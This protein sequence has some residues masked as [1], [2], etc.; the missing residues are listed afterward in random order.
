MYIALVASRPSGPRPCRSKLERVSST[1]AHPLLVPPR[2]SPCRQRGLSRGRRCGPGGAGFRVGARGGRRLAAG[3]GLAMVAASL[4]GEPCEIPG[5]A[6]SSLVLRRGSSADELLAVARE[7]GAQAVYFERCYEPAAVGPRCGGRA[8]SSPRLDWTTRAFDGALLTNPATVRTKEGRPFR[9][10]TPFWRAAGGAIRVAA[11]AAARCDRSSPEKPA[12]SLALA[13]LDLLPRIDW[14]AGLPR[15]WAPGEAGAR[16][17]ARGFARRKG[18]RV[19]NAARLPRGSR[20]VAPVAA[21][22]LRRDLGRGRLARALRHARD[23][24]REAAR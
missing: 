11:T 23:S 5:R 20:D 12:G 13:D 10:F 6:G 21:S 19:P 1:E 4:A 14:A 3:C 22:S 9:V 16:A 7:T 8:Q 15:S 18:E 17:S 2:S 24:G